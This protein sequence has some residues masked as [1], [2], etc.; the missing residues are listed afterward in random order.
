MGGATQFV[1]WAVAVAVAVAVLGAGGAAGRMDEPLETR[2]GADVVRHIF[3]EAEGPVSIDGTPPVATV[4]AGGETVGYLF[5]T[6][7]TVHPRG[8]SGQSFDIVVGLE[9]SG[10]IRGH[11]LLEEREPLIDPGMIT[12][13][14]TDRYLAETHG[15]DL[16]RG[17]RFMPGHVDGVSGATVSV[18]AM[19]R[20][21]LNAAAAVG[22]LTGVIEDRAGGL[23]LD[24]VAFAPRSWNDL[25]A[26]GSVRALTVPGDGGG[27]PTVFYA[28]LATPPMIG[29]N[30][31]GERRFRKV[32]EVTAHDAHQIV[33]GSV[34]PRRWLPA[35][36]W[37][38]DTIEGARLVQGDTAL[39]LLTRDFSPARRL[40]V[41]G[42]PAFDQL[43][44]FGI[45]GGR[46]FDPLAPWALEIRAG[47][48]A[49]SLPYRVPGALVRGDRA[50][51]EDAGFR[52][53]VLVGVGGWRESTLTDWQRLWID[54]QREIAG[55]L[56]LL[57]AVTAVMAF[58]D[59]LARSRR[60]HRLV[61]TGLLAVTL[62]WLG[63]IAGGQLTVLTAISWFRALFG[64]ADWSAILLDPL[65]VILAGYTLLTLVLWGRG[66]FCGWLCPFGALQELLNRLARLAR[67][68][69]ATVPERLQQRLWAVK[70]VVA[71]GI[72]A[73]AAVAPGAASTA[74]EIEPFQTAITM[75][76]AR[77][78][79]YMAWAAALLAAGLFVERFFCRYLC[80]LGGVLSVL[81]RI[82]VLNWLRRR[83]ECGNPCQVCARS[84]PIGAIARDGA[85]DMNECL[86]CLD[87][88]V[89]Y[90]D[91]RRCPPLAARHRRRP[92][93]RPAP[94]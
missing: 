41:D 11:V 77:A 47:A 10:A 72:L 71:A 89:D 46:G 5:S 36:P 34:G 20:A 23:S 29:R 15:Y 86:Q 53:P 16:T 52:E 73:L 45:A 2:L 28:A 64:A 87:C 66:V 93:A 14:A 40:P 82:H 58:Q 24:R 76:F 9:S 90:R 43:A 31:L 32:A 84:C 54:K 75:R 69:Q 67:V 80:P 6:H 27:E 25:R 37:L 68:P 3:P 13:E 35:N 48:R 17:D 91:E 94:A 74:A 70:Y 4:R 55:L 88:Q 38:A 85:I 92:P 62:V 44:R 39:D 57:L 12:P 30:L 26:D 49:F 19:R 21:V 18:T 33:V 60:A 78:W 59:E 63:W 8:Y 50:A 1:R 42:A 83:P 65:L 7:E 51:L 22:Y 61:R 81:G 56:A 79:P